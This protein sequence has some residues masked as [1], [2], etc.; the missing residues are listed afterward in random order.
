ML[1]SKIGAHGS[2]QHEHLKCCENC[3]IRDHYIFT[4]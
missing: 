1:A 3:F 4:K 2:M